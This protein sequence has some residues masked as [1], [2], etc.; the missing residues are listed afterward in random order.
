MLNNYTR[1]KELQKKIN[2]KIKL[3]DEYNIKIL[4]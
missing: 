1:I 4:S 2:E 3:Y